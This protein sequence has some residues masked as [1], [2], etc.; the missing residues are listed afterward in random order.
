MNS[1]GRAVLCIGGSEGG[2][3]TTSARALA[4]SG[5]DVLA[6]SYFGNADLP[7]LTLGDVPLEYF[8]EAVEWIRRVLQPERGWIALRG[9]SRGAEA[10]LVLGCLGLAVRAIIA[11]VPPYRVYNA[12]SQGNEQP[13]STWL[14]GGKP[15]APALQSRAAV[16][17]DP[18]M[19]E[20]ALPIEVLTCP[21]L[22]ISAMD[23]RIWNSKEACD[24]LVLR[25]QR[26]ASR[27]RLLHLS[28]AEAGHAIYHPPPFLLSNE[29]GG[30]TQGN[31]AAV[32]DAWNQS[33]KFL[34]ESVQV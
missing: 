20:R 9:H 17:V 21:A 31:R 15:I 24:A 8:F 13:R 12:P 2:A 7:A 5:Y 23:D 25:H 28:Y 19:D 16:I 1:A 3:P 14:W 27:A 26:S 30:T 18:D 33:L 29:W 34:D 10:A 32:S 4:K 6:L 22:L 11:Y